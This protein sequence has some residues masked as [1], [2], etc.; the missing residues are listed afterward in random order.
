M[1]KFNEYALHRRWKALV[2]QVNPITK[3]YGISGEDYLAGLLEKPEYISADQ[4][5][6]LEAIQD[7]PSWW[8][9]SRLNPANLFR[10]PTLARNVRGYN[11]GEKGKST[12]IEK[13]IQQFR[14][15]GIPEEQWPDWVKQYAK[16]PYQAQQ[17]SYGQEKAKAYGSDIARKYGLGGTSAAPAAAAPTTPSG[18][19]GARTQAGQSAATQSAAA[20]TNL[21]GLS[22]RIDSL[23]RA[24]QQLTGR[25]S[26]SN[27]LVQA[28]T[29][30]Q[31]AQF[32]R[33]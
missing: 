1:L 22:S 5:K 13:A 17:R 31:V 2:E 30:Q 12:D 24:V 15:S 29:P 7:D 16:S 33:P 28:P 32:G 27:A 9:V 18:P 11:V 19:F 8:N 21:Q 10:D 14:N 20:P 3:E 26:V 6:L 4:I 25:G 23:E